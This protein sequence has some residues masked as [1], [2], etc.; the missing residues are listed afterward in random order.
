MNALVLEGS[1]HSVMTGWR[2]FQIIIRHNGGLKVS[3]ALGQ[4]GSGQKFAHDL[5]GKFFAAGTWE[6]GL[7]VDLKSIRALCLQSARLADSYDSVRFAA[8]RP[9]ILDELFRERRA[10]VPGGNS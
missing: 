3:S 2:H 10:E 9:E 5:R 6:S 8:Q 4:E 7:P 1:P